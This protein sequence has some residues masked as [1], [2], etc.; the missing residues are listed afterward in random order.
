MANYN[1]FAIQDMIFPVMRWCVVGGS[2]QRT[3]RSLTCLP[4]C[5]SLIVFT[6]FEVTWS[7]LV[8]LRWRVST[9]L[10]CMPNVCF[11][12]ILGPLFSDWVRV[13][14]SFESLMLYSHGL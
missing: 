5:S 10:N 2:C 9:P 13:F 12:D 14:G 3:T 8:C 4:P 7:M 1:W 6:A 11:T